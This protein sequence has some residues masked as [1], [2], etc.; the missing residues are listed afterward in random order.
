[1]NSPQTPS[2]PPQYEIEEVHLSDYLNVLLRRK[3]IF[4]LAFFAVFLGVA[5]YTYTMQGEQQ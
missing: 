5:F 3:R 4:L 2:L 1:M